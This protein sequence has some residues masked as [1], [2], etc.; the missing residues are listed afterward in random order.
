MI[1]AEWAHQNQR[2]I[3]KSWMSGICFHVQA[4]H[5][6]TMT[7]VDRTNA[8]SHHQDHISVENRE[9]RTR[10]IPYWEVE[11]HGNRGSS[12]SNSPSEGCS[13]SG[14]WDHP[15]A[16][17]KQFLTCLKHRF[18]TWNTGAPTLLKQWWL[19]GCTQTM[20]LGRNPQ[21]SPNS[22]WVCMNYSTVP[23]R[24][25]LRAVLTCQRYVQVISCRNF[26]HPFDS[27][28]SN[29]RITQAVE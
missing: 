9:P 7:N 22:L 12:L 4:S 28:S 18:P 23:L 14:L 10:G 8:P 19:A 11:S 2:L 16:Y 20:D 13:E 1:W 15:Q 6:T 25:V 5:N 21:I 27:K 17:G 24:P 26:Q 3:M 29:A